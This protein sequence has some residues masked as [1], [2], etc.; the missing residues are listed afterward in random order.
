EIILM[1]GYIM[2]VHLTSVHLTGM[3]FT[4]VYLMGVYFT[5]VHLMGVYLMG[6]YLM[7]VYL[8]GVH[9]I[10]VYL[11]G[12]SPQAC[13]SWRVPHMRVPLV[14]CL[15]GIQCGLKR[16]VQFGIWYCRCIVLGIVVLARCIG[17]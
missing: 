4:G 10:G 15:A 9:L 2:G 16:V 12:R 14:W 11:M 6:V 8:M 17:V 3:Y 13:I 7:G 5:G 1:G